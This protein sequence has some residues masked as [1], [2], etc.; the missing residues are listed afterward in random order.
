MGPGILGLF[1]VYTVL[2]VSGTIVLKANATDAIAQVQSGSPWSA[3]VVWIAVGGLL[4]IAS[5][6]AW[7]GLLALTPATQAYPIAVGLTMIGIALSGVVLL[8]EHVTPVQLIGMGV[9]VGG[10]AM[11]ATGSRA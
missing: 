8:E 4:H 11:V 3:P 1:S 7:L 10:I 2:A 6:V 9:I 5:F